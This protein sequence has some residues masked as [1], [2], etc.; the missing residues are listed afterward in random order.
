MGFPLWQIAM[1]NPF[2][3]VHALRSRLKHFTD[4]NTSET[5][6]VPQR[7]SLR[8]TA[9]VNR[10]EYQTPPHGPSWSPITPAA[11]LAATQ[12]EYAGDNS[13]SPQPSV[14]MTEEGPEA[15]TSKI[16]D[17]SSE[18][19]ID[20]PAERIP[21]NR[22]FTPEPEP[23]KRV[24]TRKTRA[25]KAQRPVT[26]PP[27]PPKEQDPIDS[28]AQGPAKLPVLNLPTKV[29][30]RILD[31]L[32]VH[33]EPVSLVRKATHRR[34]VE[35]NK[36]HI[37]TVGM[38]KITRE[39]QNRTM[40]SNVARTINTASPTNLF[41]VCRGL[42]EAGIKTYYGKN[43][44][45]FS[46]ENNLAG[47]AKSIGSRHRYVKK[48]EVKSS[49][50]VFFKGNDV[51]SNDLSMK[52]T[53]ILDTEELRAF[54]DI[55]SVDVAI[56]CTMPWQRSTFPDC[57]KISLEAKE[58]CYEYAWKAI[59]AMVLTLRYYELNSSSIGTH[60]RILFDEEWTEPYYESAE[61][62]QKEAEMVHERLAKTSMKKD[63]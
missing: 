61:W 11:Q 31:L 22:S 54:D 62:K 32:L 26:S 7:F 36:S 45:S 41:L 47:W 53:G 59:E 24:F 52:G 4:I 27:A 63:S 46:D 40:K 12:N 42:R 3:D 50:E 19:D 2:L 17:Y 15:R 38:G 34:L 39:P 55:E 9:V 35:S 30:H 16:I 51:R 13:A 29:L 6:V 57:D 56:S 25:K 33:P 48:V 20:E 37:L 14:P 10:E 23:K 5:V 1:V 49:W 28:V 8:A 58:M 18:S 21:W 43:T 60:Q 44:F